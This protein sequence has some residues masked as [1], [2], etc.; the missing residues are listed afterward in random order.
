MA[1]HK[2][3]L[4]PTSLSALKTVN[5]RRN[6]PRRTPTDSCANSATL[7]FVGRFSRTVATAQESRPTP[8]K[9]ALS[10]HGSVGHEELQWSTLRGLRGEFI[11]LWA[12]PYRLLRAGRLLICRGRLAI[13]QWRG[14][15]STPLALGRGS[16]AARRDRRRSELLP[17]SWGAPAG[18]NGSRHELAADR[19]PGRRP[20]SDRSPPW[21]LRSRK[22]SG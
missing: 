8:V 20:G 10:A 17:P 1:G 22:S 16:R 6:S 15:C 3:P 19:C 2:S 14:I 9:V 11:W 12:R 21:R 5:D 13:C 7:G 18:A 4:H